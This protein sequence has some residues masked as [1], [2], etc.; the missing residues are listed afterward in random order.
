[1]LPIALGIA[2][3]LGQRLCAWSAVNTSYQPFVAH[4]N[5]VSNQRSLPAATTLLR[6]RFSLRT[7]AAGAQYANEGLTSSLLEESLQSTWCQR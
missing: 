4:T 2:C 6:R 7:A 3:G 5:G 1:M